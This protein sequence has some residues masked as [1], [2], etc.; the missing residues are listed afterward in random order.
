MNSTHDKGLDGENRA[1]AYL[2]NKG[3]EIVERNFR[4][5]GGEIDIICSRGETLFFVEVKSLPKG[6]LEILSHELNRRK[7][8]KIIKTAKCY[9]Q[10]NRQYSNRLIQFDVLAL[11]VPALDPVYHISNAFSE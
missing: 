10:K 11:D 8:Q 9:L 2:R 6:N 4:T 7:Q 3:Y 1:C 5:R